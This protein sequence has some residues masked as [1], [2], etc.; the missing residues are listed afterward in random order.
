MLLHGGVLAHMLRRGAQL[1]KAQPPVSH[2]YRH[3]HVPA[4]AYE[5]EMTGVLHR[6]WQ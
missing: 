4:A 1:T 2:V 5:S 3:S 6:C